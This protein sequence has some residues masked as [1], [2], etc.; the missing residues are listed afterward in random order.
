[1]ETDAT[2]ARKT[3]FISKATPGDDDFVLWLAPRLEAAGY[4]VFADIL[5]LDRG[6][7][8][9]RQITKTLQNQSIKMLLCCQDSTLERNGVQDEIGIATDLSKEL[10]DANFIIPLK[11]QRYKKL[12]GIGELQYID[13]EVSWAAGLEELLDTLE[14][15]GVPRS[16]GNIAIGADWEAYR[17]KS[18]ISITNCPE[19]LTSN[20]L[21]LLEI[22]DSLKFF[23]PT[24]AV[25]HG[26]M[27]QTCAKFKYP[28][29]SFE[30]GFLS[31][32]S[33]DDVNR[34]FATVGPFLIQHE[35]PISDF[36]ELGFQ[37]KGIKSR[38]AKNMIVSMV[39]DA[40]ERMMKQKGLTQ[41]SWAKQVGFH[42]DENAIE[43]G[44]KVFWGQQGVR[45]SSMLRNVSKGY[46]WRFGATGIPSLW[47]FPHI[48]LK[49]RVVFCDP[50][51]ASSSAVI[52]DKDKQHRLRRTICKTWRNKQWHGRMMAM[53][54]LIADDNAFIKLVMGS[55]ALIVVDATPIEFLSPVTTDLPD[56]LSDE[57]DE[58]DDAAI[59]GVRMEFEDQI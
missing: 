47:P 9:R 5:C 37:A 27:K 13:F 25:D 3:L 34:E 36:L 11:L 26:V 45:R 52:D 32:A 35:I 55:E 20:W 12:F 31:F 41:Y 8:W 1:M 15:Q 57:D 39:R 21:R 30:R 4:A 17:L 16:S 44:K 43:I 40:W 14:K 58:F 6:G 49:T 2:L 18:A 23:E 7:R 22:P 51:S 38:D 33:L 56:L 28:A 24:G 29:I 10:D 53:L 54:Q 50:N 46:E 48:K 42:V 19:T 59:L